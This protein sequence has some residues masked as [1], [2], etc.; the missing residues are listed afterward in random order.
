MGLLA[1]RV[2]DCLATLGMF[3][4]AGSMPSLTA[5]PVPAEAAFLF[6]IRASLYRF[7]VGAG[8]IGR[9]G[10][11]LA[12]D[13]VKFDGLSISDAGNLLLWV[14]TRDR[15]LVDENVLVSVVAA[16]E[17]IAVLHIEPFDGAQHALCEHVLFLAVAD[18]NHR[19]PQN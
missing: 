11:L 7:P 16:N 2:S 8:H 5:P 1:G 4:H 18:F 10:A 12:D 14:V 9:L 17:A 3:S 6:G 13:H 15:G 19:G